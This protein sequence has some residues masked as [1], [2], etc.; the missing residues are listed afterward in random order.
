VLSTSF[1][2]IAQRFLEDFILV[3]SVC[4]WG[5]DGMRHVLESVPMPRSTAPTDKVVQGL[6]KASQSGFLLFDDLDG[7]SCVVD[8]ISQ[9]RTKDS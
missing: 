7:Q 3:S 1:P 6:A 9:N 8:L 2:K 4:A 5:V